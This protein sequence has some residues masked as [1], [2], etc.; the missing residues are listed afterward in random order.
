[1]KYPFFFC[2]WLFLTACLSIIAICIDQ[3]TMSTIIANILTIKRANLEEIKM[4]RNNL[5]S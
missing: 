2:I 1:M 4:E 3:A 5:D